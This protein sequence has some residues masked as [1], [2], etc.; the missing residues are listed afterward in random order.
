MN[1]DW[2]TLTAL[3]V[4][5][6]AIVGLVELAARRSAWAAEWG[7]KAIHL[8]VGVLPFG[9]VIGIS[10][11]RLALLAPASFVLLNWLSYRL[12]LSRAMDAVAR[13]SLGTVYYPLSLLILLVLLWDTPARPLAAVAMLPMITGDA[14][15]AIAGA[16]WGPRTPALLE[17]A[18]SRKSLAGSLA[19][20]AVSWLSLAAGLHWA[21]SAAGPHLATLEPLALASV[22]GAVALA[23]TLIELVSPAGV[24]NITVPLT[25]AALLWSLGYTP[26]LGAA[27]ALSGSPALAAAAALLLGFLFAVIIAALA[28]RARALSR[29]GAVAATAVGSLIF[30]LGGWPWAAVL[31]TFFL[32]GSA[33]SQLRTTADRYAAKG[34]RRDLAQVFANAGVA[35]LAA[36]LSATGA[37]PVAAAL[38]LGSM[39]AATADTWATEIGTRSRRQPRLITTWQHVAPGTSGGVTVPGLLASVSG[40]VAIAGVGLI[41]L[42]TADFRLAVA[43]AVGGVVGSLTDSV[44]G[45]TV[46]SVRWCPACQ[47]ATERVQH[48]CGTSTAHHRGLPWL[49]NDAVNF[50]STLVGGAVAAVAML[51]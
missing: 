32:S 48:S 20:L 45:A 50:F 22:A 1:R 3:C 28:Y 40:A 36:I 15:A 25:T 26:T 29:S 33:L 30:G 17:T 14:A 35:V 24:D 37:G 31:L 49:D 44:L 23:V 21:G 27:P 10:D 42:R 6:F 19:M 39:A 8:G 38:F 12:R 43:A 7:R 34:G 4:Y 47:V 46:Q 51:L 13:R 9:I 16:I 5:A 11:R 41:C 18:D 2:Q